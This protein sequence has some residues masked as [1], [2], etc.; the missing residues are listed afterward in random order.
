MKIL[1]I[2]DTYIMKILSA[3]VLFGAA[4]VASAQ[5][6]N[7]PFTLFEPIESQQSA[8]NRTQPVAARSNLSPPGSGPIFTLV[9]TSR[10]GDRRTAIVRH[11]SGDEIL[12]PLREFGAT[13]IPGYESFNVVGADAASLSIRYPSSTS[14]ADYSDDGVR[15]S[16][17]GNVALLSLTTAAPIIRR[18][19]APVPGEATEASSQGTFAEA[20]NTAT[21]NEERNPFAVLRERALN[22]DVQPADPDTASRRFRPRRIAPEDVPPG[23]R[24]VS[25]PFGDR[26]VEQ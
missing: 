1:F 20:I 22:G 26:L 3:S 11:S 15:C 17:E 9:G 7:T 10:I 8:E 14:C 4:M 23:F 16:A 19:P 5:D 13:P 6:S 21:S 12:V 24:V 2:S 25:T 18:E